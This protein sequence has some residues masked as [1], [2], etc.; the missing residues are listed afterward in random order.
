M[1]FKVLYS[2]GPGGYTT[3]VVK[4]MDS[5]SLYAKVGG[6]LLVQ[7]YSVLDR[8]I[9]MVYIYTYIQVWG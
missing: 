7:V 1:Y 8:C 4:S 6:V 3:H 9:L 2:D 5:R